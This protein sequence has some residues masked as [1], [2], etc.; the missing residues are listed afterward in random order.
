[1]PLDGLFL[2]Y[3]TISFIEPFH[4]FNFQP[5][6]PIYFFPIFGQLEINKKPITTT[7][8]LIL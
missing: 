3:T 4:I 1:M 6:K 5:T 2:K 8:T 7:N